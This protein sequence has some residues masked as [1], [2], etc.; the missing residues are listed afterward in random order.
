M[1]LFDSAMLFLSQQKRRII[2]PF[3]SPSHTCQETLFLNILKYTLQSRSFS[4]NSSLIHAYIHSIASYDTSM[5]KQVDAFTISFKQRKCEKSSPPRRF[6]HKPPFTFGGGRKVSQVATMMNISAPSNF[7]PFQ[8][9]PL[10][11]DIIGGEDL[12]RAL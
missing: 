4:S 9:F 11:V 1:I 6:I 5:S 10:G 2:E 8:I 7:P 3:F 12:H